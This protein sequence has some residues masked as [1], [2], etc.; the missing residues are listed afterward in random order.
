MMKVL[1]IGGGGREHAIAWKISQSKGVQS[2]FC[3]PG[4]G[5]ISEIADCVDINLQDLDG[6]V[7]FAKREH[8][9]LVVVGP[10]N[11]LAIGIVDYFEEHDIPIFGP[12]KRAHRLKQAKFSQKN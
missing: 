10:E 4:N 9:D 11:P 6:L 5:G 2:I 1:I 7:K 3:I 12:R 8:I